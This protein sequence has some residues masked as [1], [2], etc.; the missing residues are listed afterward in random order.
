MEVWAEPGLGDNAPA[1]Q[2]TTAPRGQITGEMAL[3]DRGRRSGGLTAGPDGA[4]ILV[5]RRERLRALLEDD[6]AIGNAVIWNI[7]ATLALR[8]RLT[9]VQQLMLATELQ[10]ARGE[11]DLTKG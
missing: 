2:L 6:P 1:R 9:N 10:A 3:L 5:L 4:V 11:A 8:L 7:A